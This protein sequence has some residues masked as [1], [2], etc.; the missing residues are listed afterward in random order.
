MALFTSSHIAKFTRLAYS[1]TV[2]TVA[3][4]TEAGFKAI[5]DNTW[6]PIPKVSTITSIGVP[7]E[8]VNTPVFDQ[9]FQEQNIGQPALEPRVATLFYNG[10]DHGTIDGLKGNGINYS[11]RIRT[12]EEDIDDDDIVAATQ[13]EDYYFIGQF[14]ALEK[15]PGPSETTIGTLTLLR[16]SDDFGPFTT[17]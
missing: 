9:A 6:L 12:L 16:R 4:R 11:F 5:V 14:V 8:I 2:P 10:T 1:V 15:Q 7:A 3:T 17:S 13:H